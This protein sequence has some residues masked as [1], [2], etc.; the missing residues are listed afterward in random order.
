MTLLI[1][2]VHLKAEMAKCYGLV[3][4]SN[5]SKQNTFTKPGRNTLNGLKRLQLD[6]PNTWHGAFNK[7][8]LELASDLLTAAKSC[9]DSRATKNQGCCLFSSLF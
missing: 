2:E 8:Q 1:L 9:H 3:S 6:V 7:A 5:L 4:R